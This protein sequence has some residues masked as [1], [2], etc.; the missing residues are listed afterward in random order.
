MET[1][2]FEPKIVG[3]L[4][5]WC[6]YQ[7]ADLAGTSRMEYPPNLIPVRVMCSGRV[8]PS[9]V[10]QAYSE[11]ADAVVI[12]GC[13]LGDCHYQEGNYKAMRRYHL[14]KK[15]IEELGIEPQRLQLEWVSASEGERYQKEVSRIFSEVRELGPLDL[16]NGKAQSNG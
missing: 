2:T 12:F 3:F 9:F 5:R 16:N 15:M 4:C 11:G 13:H 14:L 8:D 7:G 6:T 1:N 10:M